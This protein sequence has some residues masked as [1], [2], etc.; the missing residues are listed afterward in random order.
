M[1][2]VT[3]SCLPA[4]VTDDSCRLDFTATRSLTADTDGRCTTEC[5]DGDLCVEKP[6]NFPVV[7][8]EPDYVWFC[9]S[10]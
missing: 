6:E 8:Q 4:D 10:V 2:A 3:E 9:H 7:K 5:N 1:S